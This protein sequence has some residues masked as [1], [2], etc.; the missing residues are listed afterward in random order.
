[1]FQKYY[2]RE[3]ISQSMQRFLEYR[4]KMEKIVRFI[5]STLNLTKSIIFILFYCNITLDRSITRRRILCYN[6]K[7]FDWEKNIQ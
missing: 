5:C 6:F 7:F 4:E 2:L 3:V 1:M